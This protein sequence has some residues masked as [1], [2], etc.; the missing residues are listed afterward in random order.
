MTNLKSNNSN[1][2]F[3]VSSYW[4]KRSNTMC[5]L[6]FNCAFKSDTMTCRCNACQVNINV[7][8]NLLY[9]PKEVI[10]CQYYVFSLLRFPKWLRKSINVSLNI[11]YFTTLE[12]KNVLPECGLWLVDWQTMAYSLPESLMWLIPSTLRNS[13]AWQAI[14]HKHCQFQSALVNNRTNTL[15]L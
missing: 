7:V 2:F 4:N 9:N 11:H 12:Q 6:Q 15:R 1:I 13:Q 8:S 14:C 5:P 3:L 10:T